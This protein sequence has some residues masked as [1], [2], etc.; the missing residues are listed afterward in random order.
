MGRGKRTGKAAKRFIDER[1]LLIVFASEDSVCAG[2]GFRPGDHDPTVEIIDMPPGAFVMQRDSAPEEL[3]AV[4]R[5]C[6]RRAILLIA[7]DIVSAPACQLVKTE[8]GHLRGL[9]QYHHPMPSSSLQ[10]RAGKQAR[11]PGVSILWDALCNV[12]SVT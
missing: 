9:L 7:L 4:G 2:K 8:C 3:H 11:S 12:L 6:I 10:P 5:L 1:L